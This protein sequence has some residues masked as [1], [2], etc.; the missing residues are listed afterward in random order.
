MIAV[1]SS[2]IAQI[3][4]EE[5][6]RRLTVTFT[7]GKTYTYFDVPKD[8]HIGFMNSSSKGQFFNTHIRDHYLYEIHGRA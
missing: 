7:T 2:A 5:M 1:V 3:G 6:S 4:Y 8:L